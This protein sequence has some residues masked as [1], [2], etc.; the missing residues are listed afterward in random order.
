[1]LGVWGT[2]HVL[3]VLQW[4]ESV[5]SSPLIRH[6]DLLC[7]R[8]LLSTGKMKKP[9]AKAV[10]S[11]RIPKST[12]QKG[13]VGEARLRNFPLTQHGELTPRRGHLWEIL[14]PRS[15]L[16]HHECSHW[17]DAWWVQWVWR[18]FICHR[19]LHRLIGLMSMASFPP[20]IHTQECTPDMVLGLLCTRLFILVQEQCAPAWEANRSV[21]FVR[22]P[23]V[24]MQPHVQSTRAKGHG[25]A[26]RATEV[27]GLQGRWCT[28]WTSLEPRGSCHP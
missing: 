6:Q 12:P 25:V 1:M 16:K 19:E 3:Q 26:S 2:T 17:R 20:Q 5:Q 11:F 22:K 24:M 28:F 15:G 9:G 21:A 10:T 4:Q 13:F 14:Q 7:R 8:G 27:W 23:L 18:S